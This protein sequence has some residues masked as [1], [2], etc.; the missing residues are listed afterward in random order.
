[1][2]RDPMRDAKSPARKSQRPVAQSLD[3]EDLRLATGD[4]G[5]IV[6]GVEEIKPGDNKRLVSAYPVTVPRQKP[7]T[8][9]AAGPEKSKKK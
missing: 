7:G 4:Q 1:M 2:K 8:P 6:S 3:A 5:P 9:A